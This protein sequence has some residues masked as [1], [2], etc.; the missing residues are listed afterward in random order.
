MKA[1]S[2]DLLASMAKKITENLTNGLETD[3]KELLKVLNESRPDFS[4]WQKHLVGHPLDVGV[5]ARDVGQR[6]V[7]PDHLRLL[8]VERLQD[9][10]CR[11][12]IA[13]VVGNAFDDFNL[14]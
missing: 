7:V 10:V 1:I 14:E 13:E 12:G 4:V 8:H 11:S 9:D 6:L 2:G 3:L 5:V